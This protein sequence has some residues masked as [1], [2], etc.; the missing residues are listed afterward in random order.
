MLSREATNT[1]ITVFNLTQQRLEP[2][3]YYTWKR[4]C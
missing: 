3:I 1:N 4:T 2:T